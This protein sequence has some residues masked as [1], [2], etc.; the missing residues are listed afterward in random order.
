MNLPL[1]V[2]VKGHLVNLSACEHIEADDYT[3]TFATGNDSFEFEFDS[4]A[5]AEAALAS[6]QSLLSAKNLCL[7]TIN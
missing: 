6:L 7:G 4:A 3:L 1:F 2:S 5:Q